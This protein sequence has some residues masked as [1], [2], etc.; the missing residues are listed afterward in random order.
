MRVYII[1]H[2][3]SENNRHKRFSGWYQTPL[4]EKGRED[5]K[6]AGELLAGIAFD[7]VFSSDLCRAG[8]TATIALPSYEAE[9]SPLLREMNVGWVA[10]QS[11]NIEP[12]LKERIRVDGYVVFGGESYDDINERV[13][14]F[15][16]EKL[17]PLDCENVAV[18]THAGWMRRMLNAVLGFEVPMSKLVCNNCCMATLDYQ[19]GNW[20]L[21]S[22]I[23]LPEDGGHIGGSYHV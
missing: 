23:N 15:M 3:E 1:R 10:N 17:E 7:K 4:T 13:R 18:F 6:K 11:L 8:E 22:W 5:A 12:A 2:G 20:K 16:T 14:R 9:P 21:H 19:D